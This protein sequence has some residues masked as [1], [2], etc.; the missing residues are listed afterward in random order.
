MYWMISVLYGIEL[1][2]S[3]LIMQILTPYTA[4]DKNVV[5]TTAI[6]CTGLDCTTLHN[7]MAW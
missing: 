6:S 4:G 7:S 5:N 1:Q 2:C 3:T